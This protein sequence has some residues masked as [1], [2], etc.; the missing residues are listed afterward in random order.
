[1][2]KLNDEQ[3]AAIERFGVFL[4]RQ[5]DAV[6]NAQEIFVRTGDH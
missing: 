3:I 4:N 5:P 2:P 6:S 1:M